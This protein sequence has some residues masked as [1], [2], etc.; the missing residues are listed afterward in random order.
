MASLLTI[1][2]LHS[3]VVSRDNTL[4]KN[5]AWNAITRRDSKE[6]EVLPTVPFFLLLVVNIILFVPVLFILA[7]TINK[8]YP[9]LA[10]I[11]A[12]DSPPDYELVTGK[13]IDIDGDG[14]VDAGSS[15]RG[16]IIVA[17]KQFDGKGPSATLM[18]DETAGVPSTPSQPVT[19]G[20]LATLRL[21]RASED[22]LFR[23]YRWHLLYNIVM[24][25]VFVCLRLVPH[26][27]NLAA[28]IIASLAT[29]KLETAWTHAV[30]STKRDGRL[31]KRLPTYFVILRVT[32]VP[33]IAESVIV[34]IINAIASLPLGPMTGSVD[35]VS[36]ARLSVAIVLFLTLYTCLLAPTEIVLT[37]TRAAMLPD[38]TNTLVP[39]DPS[40]QSQKMEQRGFMTWT[41]AWRTLSRASWVRIIKIY[42]K[43]FATTI[44]TEVVAAGLIFAQFLV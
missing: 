34:E 31:W 28:S 37:R 19:S 44:L 22:G 9:T 40:I 4:T 41:H 29:T 27:P 25:I 7:Y 8:L 18:P 23:A 12:A 10:I 17:D 16:N 43:I 20:L 30:V 11:E 35:P 39:L 5:T 6:Q 2:S 33:L 38:D 15:S 13:E 3:L 14:D 24:G 26:I 36:V 21:L 1:R 32:I 42:A